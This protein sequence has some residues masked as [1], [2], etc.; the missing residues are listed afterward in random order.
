MNS[1]ADFLDRNP[2]MVFVIIAAILFGLLWVV[3]T[4]MNYWENR[5]LVRAQLLADAKEAHPTWT[6]STT[7]INITSTPKPAPLQWVRTHGGSVRHIVDPS[8]EDPEVTRLLCG[9]T[10]FSPEAVESGNVAARLLESP[11]MDVKP[12][13]L[14]PL[15]MLQDDALVNF[16]PCSKCAKLALPLSPFSTESQDG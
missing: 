2:I 6:S 14:K 11:S 10:V 15:T 3:V 9:Q 12:Y 1:Y 16:R 8:Q 5:Q 4:F 13:Q 7:T